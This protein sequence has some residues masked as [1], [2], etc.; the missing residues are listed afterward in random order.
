MPSECISIVTFKVLVERS[1]AQLGTMER[2][3]AQWSTVE[4]SGAHRSARINE[5][6][7]V[8]SMSIGQRL[9]SVRLLMC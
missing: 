1:G 4:D 3:G 8:S 2:S 6:R 5:Y 7:C 9:R